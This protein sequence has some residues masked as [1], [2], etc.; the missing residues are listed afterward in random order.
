MTAPTENWTVPVGAP[1]PG[2]IALTTAVKVTAWPNTEGL[3]E[4]AVTAV[5]VSPLLTV[6]PRVADVLP[7]KLASP[8]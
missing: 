5:A 1:A 8:L 4:D 6:W 2:G 3:A 7:L